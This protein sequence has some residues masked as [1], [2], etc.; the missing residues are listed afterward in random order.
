MKHLMTLLALVVAVT[1]GAQGTTIHEYPWNPDWNNDNFVGSS[2]LT[3]FLSAFGSE[4]GNPPEPCDY[5]G[6]PLEDLVIGIADGSIILDSIYMEYELEDVSTY[7]V[8]GC[9]DPITD[10]LVFSNSM[11]LNYVNVYDDN[12]ECFTLNDSYGNG[13]TVRFQYQLAN[14][15]YNWDFCSNSL[16]YLGFLN[17]GFFG[18]SGG[19]CSNSE[20]FTIPFPEDWYLDENGI[21][22]E[23]GWSSGDWPYYANYLH[24]LPYWHYAE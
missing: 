4:F 9:P 6:T 23:S 8:L 18:G 2:D 19:F 24:I 11:L 15:N 10:T 7:Y 16:S 13:A 22:L 21:H 1:A 20:W 12:W 5:D 17:D 14:G 3:G